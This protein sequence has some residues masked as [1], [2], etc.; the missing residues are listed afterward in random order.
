MLA[1][2]GLVAGLGALSAAPA[3]AE[4]AVPAPVEQ[5]WLSRTMPPKPPKPDGPKG[6]KK[7]HFELNLERLL[8][9]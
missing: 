7:N 9:G 6:P 3:Q 1:V 8:Q 2:A 5:E 4:E